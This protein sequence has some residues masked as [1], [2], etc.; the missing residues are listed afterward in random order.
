LLLFLLLHQCL[1]KL[2]GQADDTLDLSRG[3][4]MEYRANV[5]RKGAT[6]EET[7]LSQAVQLYF[8]CDE[9]QL[10]TEMYDKLVTTEFGRMRS[11][12]TSQTR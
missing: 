10:A 7:E 8:Y 3:K 6:G 11:F 12:P 2:T 4:A 9:Y 5:G 1:L